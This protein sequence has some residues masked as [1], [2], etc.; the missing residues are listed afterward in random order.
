MSLAPNEARQFF[1]KHESYC[2]IDLPKYFSFSELLEKISNAYTGKNLLN[3]FSQSKSA[4]GKLDDVNHLLY[5]NKDGKL[6]WRPF[7]I[8][9]PLVYVA[10]VHEITKQENWA[11]LQARFEKFSKNEKIKC[12]SIPV[13]SE[14]KQSDKAQQIS[15][16][17]AQVEQ[18]SIL[19]SLEYDYVFD[20]DVADCY[21]SIYTHSIAWA[22][23]GKKIAKANRNNNLLG[24]FIDKSIQNAQN[25][26]TN[27][28]PQGSVLMDFIAEI[29][30]GYIDRILG[31]F[32]KKQKITNYQILRYRDDYR[33]FFCNHNDGESI[34][35]ILSEIMMPFGF[36][37]NASKTKG[38]Q[39]VI[40]QS[41]KKDKLAWLAIPQN[42]RISL[43]KQL[44]LIRQHSIN[45]ANS[46]SLNTALNKFDKQI[47][48]IRNRQGKVRNI[49]QLISIAT[50]IAYHNP[51]VIPVCCAI[52]SKLL[53]ELDDS[54]H[55][56][57]LI[58]S[59]LSRISNSG[60]AQ[61]WLQRMLKDNLSGF[62]FSEKICELQN[63]Q[64]SLWNYSWVK[65]KNMLNILNKTSIFL[66][67]EF[68][69]LDNIIPNNEIDPFDY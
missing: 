60:F 22:V 31:V 58:Y 27:G 17:W 39:D 33:M 52:I 65:G 37:L 6:S 63:N 42:N 38:S 25:Q 61:I 55:M 45:Y 28:I 43:Q 13:Q 34:L 7:Q 26:Q 21:G 41:I 49:E 62:K 40:T 35:K 66:Q 18:Q 24:N 12:L 19:L 5:A 59:K 10:L 9:N 67:A 1:L 46:G 15:N 32:L 14:N 30:L 44:L 36:K 56:S 64:I 57:L 51:R 16:W 20:T 68:D 8:I 69:R 48:R 23:E 47:E 4:M 54:R 3:D 11:K 2:N 53:S 50:D 29:I